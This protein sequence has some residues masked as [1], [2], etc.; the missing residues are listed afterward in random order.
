[1][2]LALLHPFL[3]THPADPKVDGKSAKRARRDLGRVIDFHMV[4]GSRP[5]GGPFEPGRQWGND[6]LAACVGQDERTVRNWRRGRTV[7]PSIAPLEREFFGIRADGDNEDIAQFRKELREKHSLAKLLV[8]A[9]KAS[10]SK[11]GFSQ[12][13]IQRIGAE[14]THTQQLRELANAIATAEE[15]HDSLGHVH[16]V[17][18]EAYRHCGDICWDKG[19]HEEA[20]R[21]YTRVLLAEQILG[22]E[23]PTMRHT[24]S[25]LQG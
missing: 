10:Q 7:P 19:L 13:R 25:R 4:H 8:D 17:T 11:I 3:A 22:V 16:P 5:T 12:S 6:D 9:R 1:M 21:Y 20:H 23:H 14:E 15:A 18:I 2:S 24:R